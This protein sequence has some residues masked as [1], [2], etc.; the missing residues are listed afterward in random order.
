MFGNKKKLSF[1]KE[2]VRALTGNEM[3]GLLGGRLNADNTSHGC[4]CT[5]K[6]ES[7]V[8][9]LVCKTKAFA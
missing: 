1:N 6:C 5:C 9:S 7:L 4:T 3:R 2:T 8:C